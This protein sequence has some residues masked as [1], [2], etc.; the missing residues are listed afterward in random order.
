MKV[1]FQLRGGINEPVDGAIR[2]VEFEGRC[3][4]EREILNIF[5]DMKREIDLDATPEI[6]EK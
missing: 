5:R 6:T 2:R 4:T 1:V 3:P